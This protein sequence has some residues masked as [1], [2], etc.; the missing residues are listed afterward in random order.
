MRPLILYTSTQEQ[1]L[2]GHLWHFFQGCG[3]HL[4]P[5]LSRQS[6]T[7]FAATAKRSQRR[8]FLSTHQLMI[9][10]LQDLR[11]LMKGR[12]KLWLHQCLRSS[13]EW[14]TPWQHK[15][16]SL[17]MILNK[18]SRFALLAICITQPLRTWRGRP[19][20]ITCWWHLQ[21]ASVQWLFLIR[22]NW[23]R[24]IQSQSDHRWLLA[25][26]LL[27]LLE[28]TQRRKALE[29]IQPR[30]RRHC[31]YS[32]SQAQAQT[33]IAALVTM[34]N[35]QAVQ[36]WHKRRHWQLNHWF[37][38]YRRCH[39]LLPTEPLH[40][41]PNKVWHSCPLVH[42]NGPMKKA[43]Q[44]TT[45]TR[46][47]PR[48]ARARRGEL[49]PRWL[50]KRTNYIISIYTHY[51]INISMRF[52]SG[53]L[54]ACSYMT[55]QPSNI[56]KTTVISIGDTFVAQRWPFRHFSGKK[57]EP[58]KKKFKKKFKKRIP[59]PIFSFNL[60]IIF[61]FLFFYFSPSPPTQIFE[62][63]PQNIPDVP[64]HKQN[65]SLFCAKYSLLLISQ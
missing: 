16:Q 30:C 28:I 57:V 13:I 50:R 58:Q 44:R 24:N 48:A 39:R 62:P 2:I 27:R 32:S 7:L 64:H 17:Y 6:T 29:Q 37:P 55:E 25:R 21:M 40:K 11:F 12:K 8:I 9:S 51:V 15:T 42:Q 49:R 56:A 4:S 20:A 65:F 36:C 35:W 26:A 22:V 34:C 60:F 63:T 45:E 10:L 54:L 19:T 31:R 59:P 52:H 3:S 46:R 33:L 5:S 23:V 47:L 41:H 14:S 18:S 43:I 1:G 61:L 38:W 53:P